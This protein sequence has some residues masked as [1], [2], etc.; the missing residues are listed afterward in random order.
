[1]TDTAPQTQPLRALI[2]DDERLLREQLQ[3]RL[4]Q[5]WPELEIIGMARDGLEAVRMA[6]ELRPDVMFLDIRMPGQTGIEAASD[7]MS[8]EGWTGELVFVTA[9]DEYAVSAFERG[10]VD[11]LLK[12]VEV[13]RL[14]ITRTR[15][16]G[17]L[18]GQASGSAPN[19]EATTLATDTMMQTLLNVQ[20]QLSGA[21]TTPKMR[22]V[23]ASMGSVTRM[24][25]VEDILFF[26]SD[27]KYTRVQT[28]DTEALIRV[29]IKDLLPQLDEQVFWQI[30]R[31]TIVN[32]GEISAVHRDDTG[33]QRVAMK[34]HPETLEVSRS[35]AHLFRNQ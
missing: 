27:E 8:L 10:A 32:V 11:Y 12:P 14:Q 31:S 1:M 5:V 21:P 22:W 6:D 16:E 28:A 3:S 7:I 19:S 26:R 15:I 25:A 9:Y 2:S 30:H 35:F 29:P 18:R 13:D 23:Q 34:R 17:R 33:R 24:I 4:K 20:R